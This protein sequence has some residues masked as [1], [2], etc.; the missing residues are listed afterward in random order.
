[1]TKHDSE[2]AL[3]SLDDDSIPYNENTDGLLPFNPFGC[4]YETYLANAD[5]TKLPETVCN[6]PTK[7]IELPKAALKYNIDSD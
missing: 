3:L 4:P 5:Y 6:I 2:F 1:M 7:L